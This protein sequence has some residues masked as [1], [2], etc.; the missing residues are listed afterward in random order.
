MYKLL[1]SKIRQLV[2]YLLEMIYEVSISFV[3]I[4]SLNHSQL[5]KITFRLK[6]L[7]C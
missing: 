2:W 4:K 3:E 6:E 5:I 7:M 1:G